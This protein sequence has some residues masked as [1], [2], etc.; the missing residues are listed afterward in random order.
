MQSRLGLLLEQDNVQ[1]N[2]ES[3]F[4]HDNNVYACAVSALILLPVV[5]LSLKMDLAT[6]TSYVTWKV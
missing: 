6:S 4:K 1:S 5:N 2:S 3:Y